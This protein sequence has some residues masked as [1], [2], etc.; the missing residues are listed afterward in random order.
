VIGHAAGRV[1]FGIG[2]PRVGVEGQHPVDAEIA[3]CME[4]PAKIARLDAPAQRLH[5]RREATVIAHRNQHALFG[6]L[7]IQRLRIGAGRCQRLD[8]H[9][10]LARFDGFH[11]VGR[12][13]RGMAGHDDSV[14]ITING[15][16]AIA[17]RD[18]PFRRK[19]GDFCRGTRRGC[20]EFYAVAFTVYGTDEA[21][22]PCAEADNAEFEHGYIFLFKAV[23]TP[24]GAV[25]VRPGSI[26]SFPALCIV[27]RLVD[28]ALV[29]VLELTGN[30]DPLPEG[31][32][33]KVELKTFARRDQRVNAI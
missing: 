22:A 23:G 29:F 15:F 1:G 31:L 32:F 17:D 7:G 10:R 6:G 25:C 20:G 2:L 9:H 5:C 19:I 21:F 24:G 18:V 11:R 28:E 4:H 8:D 26:G 30:K 3:R 27:Q 16:R 13:V 33:R 12:M 14:N